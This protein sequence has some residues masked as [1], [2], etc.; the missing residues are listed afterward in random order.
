MNRRNATN[1]KRSSK[2]RSNGGCAPPLFS[3]TDN[4]G[5]ERWCFGGAFSI[6]AS[7]TWTDPPASLFLDNRRRAQ[8]YFAAPPD[9]G[10]RTRLCLSPKPTS[11]A[12]I[13]MGAPIPS[14]TGTPIC[15]WSQS[16]LIWTGH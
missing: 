9:L 15:F 12:A 6:V 13:R 5:R 14:T 16:G 3:G 10:H 8:D 11:S 7:I 1:A 4:R 2:N